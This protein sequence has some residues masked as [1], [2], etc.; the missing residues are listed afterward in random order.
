MKRIYLIL[1]FLVLLTS[2]ERYVVEISDVTL[3][4]EYV[5]S[6]IDTKDSTYTTGSTYINNTLPSPFDTIEINHFY[7]QM[8][9]AQIYLNDTSVSSPRKW[10][11]K[12]FYRILGNNSY[13]SGYLQFDLSREILFLIEEDGFESLQLK[14]AGD[15]FGNKQA[16]TLYL[17]RIGP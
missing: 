3:S 1:T 12:K 17:T 13:S 14:S 15:W 8:D 9:Y 10:E 5:I 11:Y 16:M 4:G 6:K 7:I 2:C